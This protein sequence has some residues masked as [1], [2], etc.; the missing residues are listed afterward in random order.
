MKLRN[1]TISCSCAPSI[2]VACAGC[3]IEHA[4]LLPN[5][6]PLKNER[7]ALERE[8]PVDRLNIGAPVL[9]GTRPHLKN[10]AV[11]D[12]EGF[13]RYRLPG[14]LPPRAAQ[15]LLPRRIADD[16]SCRETHYG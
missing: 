11:N 3:R 1:C 10:V 9:S 6:V 14:Y 12:L 4:I 5:P 2:L 16:N 15:T 7:L 8:L 13:S